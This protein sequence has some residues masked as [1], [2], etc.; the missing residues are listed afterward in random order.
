MGVHREQGGTEENGEAQGTWEAQGARVWGH[1]DTPGTQ[2]EGSHGNPSASRRE[3]QTSPQ[4]LLRVWECA[5]TRGTSQGGWS[6]LCVSA[7]LSG[8]GALRNSRQQPTEE[9]MLRAPD[10]LLPGELRQ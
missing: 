5:R 2:E 6:W 8:H 1:S 10:Q 9:A 7:T 3:A 4:N